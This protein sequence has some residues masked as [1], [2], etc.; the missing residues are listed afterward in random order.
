MA[1]PK[2]LE[3]EDEG[4]N[5]QLT[6]MAGGERKQIGFS[7]IATT[8]TSTSELVIDDEAKMRPRLNTAERVS[9]FLY[10]INMS[11]LHM[12]RLN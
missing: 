1:Y 11:Q 10:S 9:I 12:E 7:E 5:I 6:D 8:P 4:M 2:L 3:K